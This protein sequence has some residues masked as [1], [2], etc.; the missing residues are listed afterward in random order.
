MNFSK[1]L[2]CNCNFGSKIAHKYI[3]YKCKLS[4][5][6]SFFSSLAM[7]KKAIIILFCFFL[8]LNES[9]EGERTRKHTDTNKLVQATCKAVYIIFHFISFSFFFSFASFNSFLVLHRMHAPPPL[10]PHCTNKKQELEST[11]LHFLFQHLTNQK[12]IGGFKFI[13]N[14]LARF[15]SLHQYFIL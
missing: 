14:F 15:V 6:S 10:P 2:Y 5:I 3:Y 12:K 7:R 11:T 4:K 8:W 1:E 13:L 9:C